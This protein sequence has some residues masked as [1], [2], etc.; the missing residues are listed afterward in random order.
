MSSQNF[1]RLFFAMCAVAVV[2]AAS[3]PAYAISTKP[4]E[5]IL[6]FQRA[7]DFTFFV[8]RRVDTPVGWY[9]TYDGFYV[10]RT[11]QKVWLYGNEYRKGTLT[12][13]KVLVGS[14]DPRKSPYPFAQLTDAQKRDAPPEIVLEREPQKPGNKN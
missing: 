9:V 3:T 6:A 4:N 1:F 13:T 8:Y 12:P 7:Y 11:P 2:F 10:Q 14:V 5:P